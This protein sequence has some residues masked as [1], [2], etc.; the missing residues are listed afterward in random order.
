MLL[1]CA[2][3]LGDGRGLEV[4]LFWFSAFALGGSADDKMRR[5]FLAP[6]HF[7]LAGDFV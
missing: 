1:R 6:T 3:P 4:C 7:R 2:P 5:S